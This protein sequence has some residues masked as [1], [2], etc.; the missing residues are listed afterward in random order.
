MN[1]IDCRSIRDNQDVDFSQLSTVVRHVREYLNSFKTK[2]GHI[3]INSFEVS[4]QLVTPLQNLDDLF[5]MLF[6][7]TERDLSE[8]QRKY[9]TICEKLV[10]MCYCYLH[11][12]IELHDGKS[13]SEAIVSTSEHAKKL[14]YEF[15]YNA[16]YELRTPCSALKGYSQPQILTLMGVNSPP[17]VPENQDKFDKI[18]FWTDEL[19]KFMDDL[20]SL[21]MG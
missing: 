3:E 20:P 2:Q 8:A 5:T 19:W 17:F 11:H 21:W 18:S 7:E 1:N 15:Y 16:A 13:R 14:A 12:F 9:L 6:K 10:A 4:Q